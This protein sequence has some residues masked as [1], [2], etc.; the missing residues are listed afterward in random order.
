MSEVSISKQKLLDVLAEL[1]ELERKLP[2]LEDLGLSIEDLKTEEGLLVISK[3]IT[4][5]PDPMLAL[6]DMCWLLKHYGL[7]EEEINK[8]VGLK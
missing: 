4:L 2:T 6:N 3:F 5:T 7:T 1:D 8:A